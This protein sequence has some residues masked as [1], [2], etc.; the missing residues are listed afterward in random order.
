MKAFL[1]MDGAPEFP[2]KRRPARELIPREDQIQPDEVDE[3]ELRRLRQ[4][5]R[6]TTP[7]GREIVRKI[8]LR[9][10]RKLFGDSP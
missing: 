2:V 5:F 4:K 7:Q 6:G 10:R 8:V 3:A 9:A 1:G